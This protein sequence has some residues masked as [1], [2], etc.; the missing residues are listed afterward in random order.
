MNSLVMDTHKH[1]FEDLYRMMEAF[2]R[3][4]KRVLPP[5]PTDPPLRTSGHRQTTCP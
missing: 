1:R 2:T 4:L 5:E 3:N